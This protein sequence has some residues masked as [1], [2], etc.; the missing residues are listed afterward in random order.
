MWMWLCVERGNYL[1]SRSRVEMRKFGRNIAAV[2]MTVNQKAQEAVETV[3]LYCDAR[4]LFGIAEQRA[5][6]KRDVVGV[7]YFKYGSRTLKLSVDDRKK[8]WK[9]RFEKLMNAENE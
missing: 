8:I 2:N 5:G 7:T 3:D 4:E 1:G 6:E 9:E